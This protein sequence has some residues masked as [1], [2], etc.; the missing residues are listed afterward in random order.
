MRTEIIGNATTIYA[1]C[2]VR[3]RVRYV[4]KTVRSPEQRL[5]SHIHAS[6][7]NARLPSARWIA[8]LLSSGVLPAIRVLERAGEDWAARER[9]WIAFYRKSEP[10]LLNVADGGEGLAGYV[11][12]IEQRAKVSAA[13]KTGAYFACEVCG[14]QFWR[15]RY[16]IA[17][18]ENRFCS[19]A[20]YGK[21]QSG[22]H[23]VTSKAFV[24]A[25]VMAAAKIKLAASH[26]RHGHEYSSE[27]VYVNRRGARV[28]RTC[29]RTQQAAYK[30]RLRA[31]P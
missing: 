14:K 20:C 4:G 9:Y 8:K 31:V 13:L 3:G 7:R 6:K 24:R 11:W 2:D 29:I 28:C 12:P 17:L 18:G 5:A 16:A 19:K 1:L 27:N 23:K 22:V 10:D 15:K 26:C 21:S 30:E 25:G